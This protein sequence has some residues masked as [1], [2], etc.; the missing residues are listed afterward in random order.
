MFILI[1]KTC[2]Q[3]LRQRV[4]WREGVG[5]NHAQ[6][7]RHCVSQHLVNDT[8]L[9]TQESEKDADNVISEAA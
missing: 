4:G 8:F 1:T 6:T 2:P 7:L 3:S 9:C 5:V